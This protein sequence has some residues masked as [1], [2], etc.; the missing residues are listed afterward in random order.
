ME[1]IIEWVSAPQ[2]SG[3]KEK[4]EFTPRRRGSQEKEKIR[5]WAE[6][7]YRQTMCMMSFLT[8]YI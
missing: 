4:K 6:N 5:K 3:L 2:I 8:E 7:I 1:Q